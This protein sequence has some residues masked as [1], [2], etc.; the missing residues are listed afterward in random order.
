MIKSI[1]DIDKIRRSKHADIS[2]RLDKDARPTETGGRMHIMVCGGTGCTSSNS[3]KIIAGLEELI[4]INMLQDDVK[5]VKTGCFGLCA[6]G[7]I[8]MIYPDHIMYTLVQ[9]EDVNEIFDSHV[10]NGKPVKRLLA[11]DKETEKIENALEN[12]DFFS[13]QMRIALR[14]CGT[15]NPEEIDE[16]I[17]RGGYLALEKVLTEME[18]EDVIDTIKD[19]QLRGRGGG[20]PTGVKWS[21]A[22]AQQVAQKYVCCNADE[23][24]PGAFM[25]RSVLE[26]DPHSVIEAMAIAGY[27]IGA[28]QGYVYVRAEYPIAVERLSIA[29]KQAE[30]YGLLG[31]DIF[32]KGFDFDLEIRLGAGAFVCGEETALMTSVEGHRGEPRPRPPFPAVK[33]LFGKPTILN[34][35]ETYANIPVIILKGAEWFSHIGTEKS[36]GTKVFAVG[37]KINNTGLVEIPMGTTLREIIYDIGGGIPNG[38]KFKAAQTGGPS[39]GCIPASELDTPIDYDSLIALG[40]MMGS[41]GLI[42]MDEDT[43]MVDLAKFFLEFTV[44]ESCGKCPPCRIGTKRMLEIVTRIT[45]GK[46]QP[47][48]LEKL[49]ILARNIKASALCGLGQT[50]PNPVLSTMKYF[51]DEYM[52]HVVEKKCPAGVCKSMLKFIIADDTCK[53]CGICK[54]NCPTGAISGDKNTPFVIDQDKCVKC[55]VCM[56]KCPFKSI[57]KNA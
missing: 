21:F 31:K 48:D 23:G 30:E 29:I 35:V 57:L 13:R 28:N 27:A 42:V 34:N 2:I 3:M 45:E 38:K 41:G 12:V 47:E 46:G 32:G 18:P 44:D 36:K 33:G 8:V 55:G 49:E 9:P 10:K 19:S 54:K 16:Y 56:E 15:I 43:C 53:H 5:V 1:A 51:R 37:G 50:A 22:A 7:P 24:D 20:F 17:A 25:D 40:S 39:G 14:N 6:E 11:G 26:G 4:R 52:A